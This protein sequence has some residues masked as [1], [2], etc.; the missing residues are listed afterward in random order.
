[1]QEIID[2]ITKKASFYTNDPGDSVRDIS[3]KILI[4]RKMH[5]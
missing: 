4:R 3:N 1:L 2:K 5:G